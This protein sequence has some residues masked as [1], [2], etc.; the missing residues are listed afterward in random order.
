MKKVHLFILLNLVFLISCN[1]EKKKFID[2]LKSI[3]IKI[4]TSY[5]INKITKSDINFIDTLFKTD[6]FQIPLLKKF[7]TQGITCYFLK[8]LDYNIENIKNSYRIKPYEVLKD[9]INLVSHRVKI[10]S[11][12]VVI[13]NQKFGTKLYTT[14]LVADSNIVL[15]EKILLYSNEKN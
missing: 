10:D 11:K 5:K 8:H 14:L 3:E 7:N 9:S 12:N 2:A 15:K 6:S 1:N 13:V 4:D